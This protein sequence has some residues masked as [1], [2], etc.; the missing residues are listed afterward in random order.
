MLFISAYA[1]VLLLLRRLHLQDW[2]ADAA[3]RAGLVGLALYCALMTTAVM[4]P[5]PDSPV[6]LAGLLAY[7]PWRGAAAVVTASWLGA[8][9]NFVLARL[10]GR[11][12]FRR[13]FPSY[14]GPVDDLAERIGLELVVILKFLPTVSFDVVSYAAGISR[15][16]LAPF[17]TATLLGV[18]P[19]PLL[20]ALIGVQ[21]GGGSTGQK[22]VLGGLLLAVVALCLIAWRRI[23]LSRQTS[24]H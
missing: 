10:L 21:T 22:L 3:G 17:A 14:A 18:L 5:L 1:G 6:A 24:L 19:G 11:E 2:A 9:G 8:M 4:S 7:G 23:R 16:R 13:R 15:M 12:L 20:A